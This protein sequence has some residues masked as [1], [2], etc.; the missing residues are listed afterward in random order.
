MLWIV[1]GEKTGVVNPF[2]KGGKA[3]PSWL[4][5]EWRLSTKTAQ[6]PGLDVLLTPG[7]FRPPGPG[8]RGM[9]ARKLGSQI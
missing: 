8:Y 2:M 9:Q 3:G 1:N 6:Q 7:P 4:F 5:E